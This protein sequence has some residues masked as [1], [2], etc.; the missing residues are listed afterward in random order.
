SAAQLEEA[1]QQ[2]KVSVA[3]TRA[4][5]A[6]RSDSLRAEIQVRNA[7]VAQG[8]ARTAWDAANASLTRAIGADQL[9]TAARLADSLEG[10]T[11]AVDDAGLRDL[12]MRGPDVQS[13]QA[14]LDAARAAATGSWTDYL[15]T[16]SASYSRSGSTVGDTPT[17]NG[18]DFDY[19]GAVRFSLS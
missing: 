8:D 17:F 19:S 7:Q 10:P 3:R 9:V 13:A 15:P 6:T 5:E 1:E 2:R 14:Q 11:L 18:S 12:A 4:K 16:V